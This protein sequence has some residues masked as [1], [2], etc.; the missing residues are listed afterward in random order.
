[1]FN[2]N[3]AAVSLGLFEQAFGER[4]DAN[5]QRKHRDK[6]PPIIRSSW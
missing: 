1:M 5:V 2:E 3:K 6:A 4:P